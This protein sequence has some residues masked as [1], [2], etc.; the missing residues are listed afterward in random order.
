M[1][2]G[3]NLTRRGFVLFI[4]ISVLALLALLASSF[5]VLSRTERTVSR[6]YVDKAR[7]KLLAHAGVERA[8]IGLKTLA[9]TQAWED[10]TGPGLYGDGPGIPIEYS[11]YPS[12]QAYQIPVPV[13]PALP[14]PWTVPGA[15]PTNFSSAGNTNG[16]SGAL[17]ATYPGGWDCYT[18]KVLDAQSMV[19]LNMTNPNLAAIL[20]ALGDAIQTYLP[21]IGYAAKTGRPVVNPIP[22]GFGATIVAFRT[23][24]GGLFRSKSD[25]INVPGMTQDRLM[26]LQDFVGVECYRDTQAILPNPDPAFPS[27]QYSPTVPSGTW[28]GRAPMNINTAPWPV[29]V[30]WA[31]GVVGYQMATPAVAPSGFQFSPWSKSATA[32]ITKNQAYNIATWIISKRQGHPFRTL[33]DVAHFISNPYRGNG[34]APVRDPWL[35]YDLANQAGVNLNA[36]PGQA[37]ALI[38]LADPSLTTNKF[39]PASPWEAVDKCDLTYYTWEVCFSSMGYFE[40]ESMGRVMPPNPQWPNTQSPNPLPGNPPLIVCGEA[41]AK[42]VVRLYNVF[43]QTTQSQLETGGSFTNTLTLP[44]KAPNLSSTFEG[45]TTMKVKALPTNGAIAWANLDSDYQ[46][47]GTGGGATNFPTSPAWTNRFLGPLSQNGDLL[48]DGALTVA[49]ARKQLTFRLGSQPAS[50]Q[51]A[52]EF[53]VRLTTPPTYGSGESLLYLVTTKFGDPGGEST[54]GGV[55]IERW[56]TRL[57]A[58]RFMWGYPLAAGSPYFFLTSN[59]QLGDVSQWHVGTWHHLAVEW[60][61]YDAPQGAIAPNAVAAWQQRCPERPNPRDVWFWIDGVQQGGFFQRWAPTTTQLLP[62]NIQMTTYLRL[63]MASK[64]PVTTAPWPSTSIDLGGYSFNSPG[65]PID[66]VNGSTVIPAG[67]IAL[68]SN[69]VIDD[70]RVYSNGDQWRHGQNLPLIPYDRFTNAGGSTYGNS[71]NLAAL[72]A[73]GKFSQNAILGTISWQQR[74]PAWGASVSAGTS[75]VNLW[76]TNGGTTQSPYANCSWLAIGSYPAQTN[77]N[78]YG[79]LGGATYPLNSVAFNP[80][81]APAIKLGATGTLPY[82]LT[83]LRTGNVPF[84]TAP[85]VEEVMITVIDAPQFM[86]WE[87]Y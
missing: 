73:Q 82:T 43:R 32:A 48:T 66:Y 38:A 65:R 6:N 34:L 72:R 28:I 12:F 22:L 44:E 63:L 60:K 71:F 4:T 33:D 83:F 19:D 20:D 52:L 42:T 18:D 15:V 78:T 10:L 17:A 1:S 77:R 74:Q 30:A 39:F 5:A 57:I 75:E 61:D 87:A 7:A 23:A 2:E 79:A 64:V 80:A 68:Y 13:L 8:I 25:L 40:I 49:N 59:Y 26:A 14:S 46:W 69:S 3:K 11:K 70:L 86:S 16:I 67:P 9:R 56:G 27:G 36:N 45:A 76:P 81:P 24:N 53:W 37:S 29:L 47:T 62:G 31:E 55:K 21:T 41:K 58:T 54:G 84:T 50:D 35:G 51:G 85:V